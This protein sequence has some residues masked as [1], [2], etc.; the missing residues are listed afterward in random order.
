ML[1]LI[2]FHYASIDVYLLFLYI[3]LCLLDL[4]DLL[5][6]LGLLCF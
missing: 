2:F 1:T 5:C 4:L 3:Y 6:F